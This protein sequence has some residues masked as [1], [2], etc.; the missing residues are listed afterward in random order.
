MKKWIGITALAGAL[1]L[2]LAVTVI[3]VNAPGIATLDASPKGYRT[4]VLDTDGNVALTLSGEESNRA[5]VSLDEMPQNLKDAFVAIE[6]ERFYRHHGIDLKGIIRAVYKGIKNGGITEGASTITQQLIKNNVFD[7]WTEEKTFSDKLTRKVQEQFLAL[8]LENEKSKEWILENYLNTINLGGGTWGVEAASKYY[9]QK[10]VSDLCLSECAILAAIPKS[11]TGYNPIKYPD[12]NNTRK[13]LVLSKMRDQGYI[14]EEEYEEAYNDPVYERLNWQEPEGDE[15]EI[16]TYFED[17]LIYQVVE[18][19]EE[20]GYSSEEAWDLIY[21]GGLT[22]YSTEDSSLQEICEQEMNRDTNYSECT[23]ASMVMIDSASGQ[24]KAMVGGRGV[25]TASLILN[26][27]T[28]SVR[29]P[30]ST[31]KIIGEYAAGLEDNSFTLGTTFDDAPYAYSDGTPIANAD[32]TYG[33]M[34]TVRNAIIES[35]NIVALKCLQDIGIQATYDQIKEF[36]ITTLTDNDK[37]ES[38]ALGGI[39]YGVTNLEMT[40]AYSALARG[41]EYIQPYYYTKVIDKEGNIILENN[42]ETHRAVSEN[43]AALLTSAMEN[44]M[45]YGTGANASFEGVELAGKSGTTNDAK[46]SWF[47]GYS[48]YLTCGVWGGFDDPAAQLET[49]YVKTLWKAAMSRAHEGLSYRS[50]SDMANLER[51]TICVKC[52]KLAVNGLC[53]DTV[54]GDMTKTEYYT[55]GTAPTQNCDCHVKVSVNRSSGE[56]ENSWM[57]WRTEKKVYLKSATPGTEDVAYVAPVASEESA[58]SSS[59]WFSWFGSSDDND[60]DQEQQQGSWWSGQNENNSG[61]GEDDYNGTGGDST[62]TD[63]QEDEDGWWSDGNANN[64]WNEQYGTYGDEE[65]EPYVYEEEDSYNWWD[66]FSDLGQLFGLP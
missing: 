39:T 20:K 34:T 50:F 5:Y 24:V 3:A 28:D 32:K 47:I 58:G 15:N 53:D 48:P 35:N 16:M 45:E 56:R 22:I 64:G 23:Q 36:G 10:E 9:F 7:T 27:A 55:T 31:M 46:D 61:P 25:K 66:E 43:T 18:D 12:E 41:G 21:K 29:Q 2:V 49:G 13:N 33:G 11:P 17:A 38:L 4:S 60:S 57:F 62:E 14:T 8:R 37:I 26:R 51:A 44:V 54:Q 1:L 63:D 52:G 42:S 40:A 30:G 19:L 65:D 6:D 59:G